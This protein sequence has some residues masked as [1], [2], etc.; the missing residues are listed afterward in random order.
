VG[1]ILTAPEPTPG[2]VHPGGGYDPKFELGR[3]F[4]TLHPSFI[5]L[6]LLVR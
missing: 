6:R 4:G 1:P 2:V 5:M 3:D